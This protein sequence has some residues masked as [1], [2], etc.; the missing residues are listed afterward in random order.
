MIRSICAG[1]VAA[2][3]MFPGGTQ[4]RSPGVP[5]TSASGPAEAAAAVA[6]IAPV[7]GPLQVLRPFQ[8]PASVYGPGHRGVDLAQPQGAL[9]LA[10]AV[11]VVRF[12]ESVAGRGVIVVVHPDGVSTEYEPV[13]AV[14]RAGAAVARGDPIGRL[15]GAH[16]GCPAACVHWGARRAG[17][18]IDP[19]ALVQP[20]GP[21]RLLPWVSGRG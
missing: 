12:A 8:A 11:G 17:R 21:V 1:L 9:V 20:L 14:V 16:R 13:R 2:L 10:A 3:L 18:Y 7:S 15:H 19:L 5:A 4:A 6:Y